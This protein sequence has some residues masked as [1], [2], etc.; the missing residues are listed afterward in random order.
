MGTLTMTFVT[1]AALSAFAQPATPQ[2]IVSARQA[3]T[4]LEDGDTWG[5]WLGCWDRQV[6]DD[7][8]AP[9]LRVCVERQG[10]RIVLRT[11]AE[12]SLVLEEFL[13]TDR[14]PHPVESA[15]CRGTQVAS[16]AGGRLLLTRSEVACDGGPRQVV[17]RIGLLQTPAA[18]LDVVVV[19]AGGR[20]TVYVRRYL[21][22]GEPTARAQGPTTTA[23]LSLDGLKYAVSVV[24]PRAVEAML[25]ETR[26]AYKLSGK[27]L[28]GLKDAGVPS[29]L[30]DLVVALSLP[31]RFKVSGGG[32]GG[33]G[34]FPTGIFG[35]PYAAEWGVPLWAFDEEYWYWGSCG[36]WD[37]LGTGYPIYPVEPGEP[38]GGGGTAPSAHGRVVNGLGYARVWPREADLRGG[39]GRQ[40]D[41]SADQSAGRAASDTN[42]GSGSV[43]PQGYSSG[44]GADTGRTAEP[45][46]P[47][48]QE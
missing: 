35:V 23:S 21:R 15:G 40:G 19:E 25:A 14:Q 34:G 17:S 27:T 38:G 22:A 16:W 36:Y 41:G 6:K 7:A 43:S 18:W 12:G 3:P 45:R 11:L 28:I 44:S 8:Q 24:S 4:A 5:P 30:I 31:D 1:A 32:G 10:D 39:D 20:E 26:P 33:F 9:G 37:C 48:P 47:P 46:T 42:A 29:E 13:P 2:A